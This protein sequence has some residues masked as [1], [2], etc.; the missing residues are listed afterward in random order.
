M[1]KL[2]KFRQLVGL[3]VTTALVLSTL[4]MVG[5]ELSFV[6]IVE[7]VEVHS[8]TTS[9]TTTIQIGLVIPAGQIREHPVPVQLRHGDWVSYALT[10]NPTNANITV[11]YINPNGSFGGF[12][13]TS[14]PVNGTILVNTT[15][16][17]RIAIR[18]NSNQQVTVIGN[19]TITDRRIPLRF[20]QDPTYAQHMGNIPSAKIDYITR[21]FQT[22]L[23]SFNTDVFNFGAGSTILSNCPRAGVARSLC[24]C[25]RPC[26]DTLS[27]N[28]HHTNFRKNFEQIRAWYSSSPIMI[29]VLASSYM[30]DKTR[31][32]ASTNPIPFIGGTA[33][34]EGKLSYNISLPDLDTTAVRVIQHELSHNFGVWYHCVPNNTARCIMSGDFDSVNLGEEQNNNI[35]CPPC[36]ASFNA[37]LH[38]P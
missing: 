23:V 24:N 7:E 14:S 34:Q 2:R 17:H 38:R 8:S 30:C 5:A 13:A 15:G 26:N 20:L 31:C 37:N 35:W 18:N 36:F 28:L 29:A 22:Q 16:T 12:V 3:V 27:T 32:D 4:G 33:L 10:Y 25:G 19:V 11:G 21:P 6:E 9:N 1:S